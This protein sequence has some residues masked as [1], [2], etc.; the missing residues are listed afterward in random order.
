MA[1]FDI[2][3]SGEQSTHKNASKRLDLPMIELAAHQVVEYAYTRL[4]GAFP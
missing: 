4:Q 3:G 2:G 1:G